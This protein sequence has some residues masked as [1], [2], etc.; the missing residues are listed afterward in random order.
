MVRGS[1]LNVKGDQFCRLKVRE[2]FARRG[3][4]L[5]TQFGNES[6]FAMNMIRLYD[7]MHAN[8]DPP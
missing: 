8:Y 1:G 5:E 4:S 2:V 6:P 7:F 3:G